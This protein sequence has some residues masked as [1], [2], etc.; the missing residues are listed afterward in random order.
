MNT[1]WSG[2]VFGE[3]EVNTTCEMC[4][5]RYDRFLEFSASKFFSEVCYAM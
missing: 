5:R 4:N 2:R 3:N 1:S